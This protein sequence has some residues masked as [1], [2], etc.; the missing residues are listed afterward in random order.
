[1][2]NLRPGWSYGRGRI[3][4]QP[5]IQKAEELLEFGSMLHLRSEV[6]PG[7]EGQIAVGFYQGDV[8]VQVTVTADLSLGLRKE[9]GRGFD[10]EDLID[11]TDR[12]PRDADAYIQITGLVNDDAWKSREF[13]TSSTLVEYADGSSILPLRTPAD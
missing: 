7:T 11:P 6:F 3:I 5:V 12:L 2:A 9:R 1:M 4:T 10:Y 8:C 13:S